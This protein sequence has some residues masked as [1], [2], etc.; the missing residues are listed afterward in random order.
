MKQTVK[1]RSKIVYIRQCII[2]DLKDKIDSVPND[3]ECT[4]KNFQQ[5][6]YK[7]Y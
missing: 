2:E 3:T 4:Y 7:M 5:K 6:F 1:T